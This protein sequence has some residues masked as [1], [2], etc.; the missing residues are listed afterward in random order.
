MTETTVPPDGWRLDPDAAR[1]PFEWQVNLPAG[2]AWSLLDTY[3]ATWQRSAQRLLDT[4][5]AGQHL[6]TAQRRAVLSFLDELVAA[7]QQ[8]G[9]V[10]SL[11]HIGALNDS[12]LSTAGLHIAWYDSSPDPA[13]LATARSAASTTGI[14]K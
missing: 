6:R 10:L 13:S 2:P 12:T 1:P 11:V 7:C 14:V 9:T 8:S 4:H 5:L 3:P